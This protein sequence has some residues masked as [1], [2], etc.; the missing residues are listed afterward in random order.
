VP[1]TQSTIVEIVTAETEY[2][3]IRQSDYQREKAFLER[4]VRQGDEEVRVL[5]DQQ[6]EEEGF[7]S[8]REDLRKHPISSARAL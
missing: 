3:K 8:D 2:L 6:K 7:Q 5:S 1:I 4:G